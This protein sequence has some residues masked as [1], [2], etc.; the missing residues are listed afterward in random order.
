[1]LSLNP[2]KKK[3]GSEK[4]KKD[5]H[6][7]H[8][9]FFSLCQGSFF[10]FFFLFSFSFFFQ[11]MVEQASALSQLMKMA[12]GPHGVPVMNTVEV[13][14]FIEKH[15]AADLN[16]VAMMQGWGWGPLSFYCH[17]LNKRVVAALLNHR[18]VDPNSEE[19]EGGAYPLTNAITMGPKGSPKRKDALAIVKMLVEAGA[20]PCKM[21][22]DPHYP[23]SALTLVG[24]MRD[25]EM[26]EVIL[27]YTP[28]LELPSSGDSDIEQALYDRGHEDDKWGRPITFRGAS[29]MVPSISA[30]KRDKFLSLLTRFAANPDAERQ[31]LQDKLETESS[32]L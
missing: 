27:A 13:L 31:R 22:T 8:S 29:V 11:T 15:P 28:N 26:L 16:W 14:D 2:A 21:T 5:L 24:W 23:H 20:D 3:E 18:G 1:L 17:D 10:F 9:F 7:S 19:H 25:F 32:K 6:D 30:K 12:Y 4:F